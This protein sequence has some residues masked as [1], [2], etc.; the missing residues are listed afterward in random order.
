MVEGF[1]GDTEERGVVVNDLPDFVRREMEWLC[2]KR[3]DPVT[4]EA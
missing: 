2:V 4:R 1:A 3:P